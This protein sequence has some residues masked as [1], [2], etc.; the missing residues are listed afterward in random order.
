MRRSGSSTCSA[1]QVAATSGLGW[2]RRL[3]ARPSLLS[4]R[5]GRGLPWPGSCHESDGGVL[6]AIGGDASRHRRS[7]GRYPP[8]MSSDDRSA[9]AIEPAESQAFRTLVLL[10]PVLDAVGS[11]LL[12]GRARRVMTREERARR[13]SGRRAAAGDR[14]A[15]ERRAGGARAARRHRGPRGRSDRCHRAAAVAGG[16]GRARSRPR[17]STP[18][19]RPLRLGLRA[20][21]GRPRR[22]AVRLGLHGRAVRATFGAGSA[23]SRPTTGGRS[24]PTPIRAGLRPRVAAPGRGGVPGAG[25]RGGPPA[26]LHDAGDYTSPATRSSRRSG[27][28]TPNTTTASG[29]R[30]GART[31]SPWYRDW[32]TGRLRPVD[33]AATQIRPTRIPDR[34]DP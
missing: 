34:P 6:A 14:R 15:L 26:V 17:S 30:P 7:P 3:L 1:S 2:A 29:G 9:G 19:R 27:A 5:L 23:R 20:V 33:P 31:W 28:R 32:M 25:P 21:A 16:S 22:A 18:R 10:Y 12:R 24:P 11:K 13:R 4:R 8:V